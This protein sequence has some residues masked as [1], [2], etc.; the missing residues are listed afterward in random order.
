[1]VSRA[2]GRVGTSEIIQVLT[3][4]IEFSLKGVESLTKLLFFLNFQKM[5]ISLVRMM[6]MMD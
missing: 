5:N 2:S 4:P 1:M 3:F 6:I